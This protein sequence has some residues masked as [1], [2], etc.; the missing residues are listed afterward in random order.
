MCMPS[1]D[2]AR[3][4]RAGALSGLFAQST[5]RVGVGHFKREVKIGE[6]VPA[7]GKGVCLEGLK[8]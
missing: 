7:P 6:A 3:E 2:W 8:G 4:F 5:R 1:S